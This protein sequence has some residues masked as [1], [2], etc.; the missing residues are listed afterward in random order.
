MHPPPPT[1]KVKPLHGSIRL[2]IYT[3]YVY[4]I[5]PSALADILIITCMHAPLLLS[6]ATGLHHEKTKHNALDVNLRYRPK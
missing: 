6:L 2:Y 5:C 3:H 1:Y 4:V